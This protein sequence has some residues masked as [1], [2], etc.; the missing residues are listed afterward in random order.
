MATPQ[1]TDD[2]L[3][4]VRKSGLVEEQRLADFIAAH[5]HDGSLSG[6]PKSV[7][8]AL[9]RDGL[10]TAFQGEQFLLGKWKGFTL[11]K[12][13]LLE[14][15]GVGGMGQIFL[16]EHTY[17]RRRVAIKVLPPTKAQDPVSLARFYREARV[18]SALEHPNI[19]KTYDIDQDANLHFLVM[20]YIDGTSLL[21]IVKKFGPLNVL[22]ACHYIRQACQGL[23]Y[24]HTAGMIHRDIK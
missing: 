17:M 12:Y 18:A 2:L 9:I 20:E 4:L 8:A 23:Q 22:R 10:I 15:I 1:T 16:C 5:Q 14:R 21:E 3:Q 6:D 24:A 11:G 7:V 19:V 13:R